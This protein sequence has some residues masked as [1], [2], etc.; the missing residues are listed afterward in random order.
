M[1]IEK[2][3]WKLTATAGGA[4]E[5]ILTT[6]SSPPVILLDGGNTKEDNTFNPLRLV[7]EFFKNGNSP[8]VQDDFFKFLAFLNEY[9][10]VRAHL[11]LSLIWSF[12]EWTHEYQPSVD[13]VE[14]LEGNDDSTGGEGVEDIIDQDGYQHE[15]VLARIDALLGEYREI[16][17]AEL[18]DRFD[19]LAHEDDDEGYTD[20][21][22]EIPE[23][24]ECDVEEDGAGTEGENLGNEENDEVKSSEG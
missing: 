21:Y 24:K 6:S 2:P 4:R 7:S 1:A 11:L 13:I 20:P 12:V 19:E 22:E 14:A 18:C 5:V 3:T 8:E 10:F 16:L 9:K 15:M 17:G 23:L